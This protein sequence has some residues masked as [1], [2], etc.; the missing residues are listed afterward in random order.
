MKDG[1][2]MTFQETESIKLKRIY[3]E[4]IEKEIVSFLNS[5]QGTIYI[6]VE[7]DGN[8]VGISN[9]DKVMKD[10]ADI[11]TTKILLRRP[12]LDMKREGLIHDLIIDEDTGKHFEFVYNM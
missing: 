10:I 2:S 7:D 5:H 11:I 3:N 4:T 12:K 8:V 1:E 6:G 9:I